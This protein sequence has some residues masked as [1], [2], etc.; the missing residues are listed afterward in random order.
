METYKSFCVWDLGA[1]EER[2]AGPNVTARDAEKAALT[3][4]NRFDEASYP[5]E[6]AVENE[7][8]VIEYYRVDQHVTAVRL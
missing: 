6:L 2:P 1:D 4:V 5:Y 8:G 7:S 3:Y